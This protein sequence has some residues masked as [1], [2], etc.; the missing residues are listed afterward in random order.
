MSKN[1]CDLSG[2]YFKNK[3]IWCLGRFDLAAVI[4]VA[5]ALVL[6]VTSVW[7][8]SPIV[9]EIPHIG[10]GYSY[11]AKGDHRLNPEHPPLA[12]DLAGISLKIAGIKDEP[13]FTSKFWQKDVNGQWEFGR[14]LIF[15]SGNDAIRLTRFAKIP[16]LIFFILSAIIIFIWTRKI[17]GYLAALM[18]IFLFSFSPTVLAHSRFVTTDMPALFGILFATYFFL[19]YLERPTQKNLW[20]AGIVFGIAQLTKYS[21]FLLVPFFLVIAVL[22]AFLKSEKSKTLNTLYLIRNTIII[23]SIG[24]LFIVWPVYYFHTWNY[25]PERQKTDTEYLLG[26]YGR[27][28]IPDTVIYLAD[29]PIVRGLAEYATGL[30]MVTQRSIGGNTTYFL[31]EVRNWAWPHYFPIVYF[32]KEPLAFWGLVIL[33]WLTLSARIKTFDP[34]S[35]IRN[36]VNWSRNHFVE[37]TMLLWIAMYWYTSIRANLNIGVRHMMPVYGFTFILLSGGLASIYRS[38]ESKKKMLTAYCL[39][40]TALFGWYLYENL[41]VYPYYLTYFNQVAGGPSGGHRYVVDSNLDWGQDLKRLSDWVNENDVKKISLDY[42]GWAD[43]SF[44]LKDNYVWI[45][46]GKYTSA[47]DYLKENPGGGYIAVSVSFYMGSIEKPETSYA[48]L[49][50]YKPITVIGNSIFVWYIPS[51]K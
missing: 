32:I 34:K 13:A 37:L 10:A 30:L 21:V 44:Y 27:R 40:L 26:S 45:W 29:K 39:L 12:K 1:F 16:Q 3:P 31:G 23:F 38:I 50:D 17:Y 36:S 24:Y 9:D 11:I 15:N 46:R 49:D 4:I 28:S 22:Y 47:K 42:F 8:D 14:K 35:V 51:V 41:S 33:V 7:N 25:P 43:Q 6:A 19:H 5:A 48:W 2:D 20:L 18:A